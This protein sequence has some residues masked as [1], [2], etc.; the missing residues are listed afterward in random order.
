[1]SSICKLFNK[2]H[3]VERHETRGI[4]GTGLGL[5]LAKQIIT[6]HH[7]TM[8]A[9]SEVGKGST[10]F[11]TLPSTSG[12]SNLQIDDDQSSSDGRGG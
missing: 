8:W 3:R 9:E 5:A 7:G 6:A 12:M 4:G 10:F 11:F 2:F 1:M